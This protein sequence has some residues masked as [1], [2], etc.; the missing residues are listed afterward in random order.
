MAPPPTF[1]TPTAPYATLVMPYSIV[2]ATPYDAPAA[3]YI[4]PA[5]AY[6]VVHATPYNAPLSSIYSAYHS[7]PPT[8]SSYGTSAASYPTPALAPS[9]EL[10]SA[11]VAPSGAPHLGYY[12]PPYADVQPPPDLVASAAPFYFAYLIPV[13][14]ATDNYLSWD[15]QVLR[16]FCTRYLEGCIDGTISCPPPHHPSYYAW[17][18]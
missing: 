3:P 18:A 16:L 6:T 2:P 10:V 11:L 1:G 14:L 9:T 8:G 5:E 17:V 13:N 4:M 12:T 7:A 15:A